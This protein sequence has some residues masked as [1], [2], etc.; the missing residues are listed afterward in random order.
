MLLTVATVVGALV[1]N[2]IVFYKFNLHFQLSR[3]I[4]SKKFQYAQEAMDKAM[5]EVSKGCSVS[6]ASKKYG[7]PRTTLIDK[8]AG[9]YEPDAK[10]GQPTILKSDEEALLVKWILKLARLGF[11]VTKSQLLDS[12]AELT[13][14]LNKSS[15]FSE[16]RPGKK[17][18]TGFL[19]RHPELAQRVSQ[20]LTA[21]CSNLTENNIQNWFEKINNYLVEN[22]FTEVVSDP[23]RM[24][25]CDE[26]AFFLHHSNKPCIGQKHL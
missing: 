18:F 12:V 14:K 5:E 8:L 2:R 25:N 3:F 21:A 26:T 1:G 22:N 23:T 24:F 6:A 16:G 15:K 13:K 17:W 4:M 7:V 20:N 10:P 11:S 9:K 19:K